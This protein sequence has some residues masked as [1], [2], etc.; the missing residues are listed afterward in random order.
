MTCIPTLLDPEQPALVPAKV[1]ERRIEQRR[2]FVTEN[3][4]ASWPNTRGAER[5]ISPAI[6]EFAIEHS[7]KLAERLKAAEDHAA[8]LARALLTTCECLEAWME[9]AEDEDKRQ[10][11][12][13]AMHEAQR[14]LAA[15]YESV[16]KVGP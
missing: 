3:R 5:R 14:A 12:E 1:A 7:A 4:P 15:Y 6:G 16:G 11:D 9:I 2:T 8:R 10:Y 13:D